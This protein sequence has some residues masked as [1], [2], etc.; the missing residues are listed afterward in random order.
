MK[1]S[2][3]ISII[4]PCYNCEKFISKTIQSVIEQTYTNWECILINDGSTDNSKQVIQQSV[5][6]DNRFVFLNETNSGVASSRNKG[7][8]LAKGDYVYFCDADDLIPNECFEL[9]VTPAANKKYDIVYAETA[10]TY[11]HEPTPQEVWTN[12]WNK[13]TPIHNQNHQLLKTHLKFSNNSLATNRLYN[14]NFIKNHKLSFMEGVNH[15]D[16]LW[17][18]ETIFHAKNIYA[19]DKTTYFY[20]ISNNS[21]VTKNLTNKNITD[22]LKML[23][24]VYENYFSKEKNLYTKNLISSYLIVFKKIIFDFSKKLNFVDDNLKQEITTSFKYVKTYRSQKIFSGDREK[25]LFNLYLALLNNYDR[26]DDTINKLEIKNNFLI[27]SMIKSKHLFS[28][29]TYSLK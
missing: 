25:E 14:L 27:K 28:G 12:I 15:E 2:L 23:I 21:S 18:F 10:E 1:H 8:K 4:I 26:I 22:Y 3:L 6:N 24:Y 7:I 19:I 9:L 29:N 17:F 16:E 11:G 13:N 20:N 5:K